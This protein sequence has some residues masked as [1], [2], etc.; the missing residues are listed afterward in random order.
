MEDFRSGA[1]TP[2]K[3]KQD[4]KDIEKI[5][6]VSKGNIE[7]RLRECDQY[8]AQID[9]E[10]RDALVGLKV[11]SQANH[12]MQQVPNPMEFEEGRMMRLS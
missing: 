3:A 11:K 12:E 6:F 7:G 2:L 5:I 1:S 9:K 8:I 10:T 4:T